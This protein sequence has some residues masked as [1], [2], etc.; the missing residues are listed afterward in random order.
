MQPLI[1]RRALASE[2]YRRAYLQGEF[3]LRSGGTA[4]EYFDKYRF[5]SDPDLL[6]AICDALSPL[7][8][9]DV[10]ALAGL[11]LGGVP[12]VTVLSQV[13]GLPALFVRK[14][15]KTYGTRQLAEGG[16]IAGRR[17][18]IVEDVVTTAGQIIES[19]YELRGRG[20]QVA[21]ALA[22]IDRGEDGASKLAAE[23]VELRALFTLDELRRADAR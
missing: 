3:T 22:V 20:A 6:R 11:E 15:A 14:Q 10:D 23:G 13:T 16:E 18:A 9:R 19:T 17:L 5:E 1:E 2:I 4:S 21:Y 12:L 7:V 8:P